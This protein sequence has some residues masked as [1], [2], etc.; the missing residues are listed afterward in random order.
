[1]TARRW[2]LSLIAFSAI[3]A[4]A[5]SARAA[6]I[7]NADD[8]ASVEV[9]AFASQGFILTKDNNY[10]NTDTTHGSFE[11]SQVG[12]NFTK[13]FGGKLRVGMQLFAQRFSDRQETTTRR[14]T[15][16]T[17]TTGSPTGSGSA[18]GG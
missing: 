6:E 11:F 2:L 4:G 9:H 14:S 8:L 17:W 15:G 12:I 10:L 18:P 13:T 16:S 1:M 7:G 3:S 5:P